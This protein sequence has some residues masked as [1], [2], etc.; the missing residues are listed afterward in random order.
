[1]SI[2][3]YCPQGHCWTP[4]INTTLYS[5]CYYCEHC[6]KIYELQFVEVRR[7]QLQEKFDTDRF[8][9]I[10]RYAK[11]IEARKNIPVDCLIKLGYLKE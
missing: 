9:D 7:E 6:N 3:K 5:D 11:I 4:V 10:K 2:D 1:M 8:D